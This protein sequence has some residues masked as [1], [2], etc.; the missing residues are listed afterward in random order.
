MHKV[1]WK[2]EVPDYGIINLPSKS[3]ILKVDV[4][5][6]KVCMWV[7][8]TPTTACVQRTFGVYPTGYN[9]NE[10]KMEHIGSVIMH[11][12]DLVLHVFEH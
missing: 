6:G 10:S 3:E 7:L 8:C 12:G 2:F 11:N 1:V 5:H 4:Q 9:V